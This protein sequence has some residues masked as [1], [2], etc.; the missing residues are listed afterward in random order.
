PL[1]NLT[2]IFIQLAR[3]L[4]S[5]GKLAIFRVSLTDDDVRLFLRDFQ[6]AISNVVKRYTVA[7]RRGDGVAN[8]VH[9]GLHVLC[10]GRS[11]PEVRR[12][13]GGS[14]AAIL[15]GYGV[16]AVFHVRLQERRRVEFR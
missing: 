6:K 8:C 14:L 16:D 13:M 4:D 1:Q 5:R 10:F 7:A 2:F 11:A 3:T 15:G 12:K 9:K